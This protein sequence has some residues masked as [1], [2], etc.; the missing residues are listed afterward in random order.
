MAYDKFPLKNLL[1]GKLLRIAELQDKLA[2]ELASKFE[3]VL[4]GGTALWRVYG[5]RRVSLDIDIYHEKPEEVM[6]HF[7][8][9]GAFEMLRGKM[10]GSDV[11]Y[12]KFRGEGDTIVE[13]HVSPPFG[14]VE[15]ADGEFRLVDGSSII[16]KT[17]TPEWLLKEKISAFRNRKK[18]RDLYDIFY[19]LDIADASRFRGEIRSLLP[20][21]KPQDFSGLRELILL[22]K[23]PEFETIE[24]KLRA[25]GSK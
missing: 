10:T 11:L 2:I 24:R 6:E 5:G 18:A 7:S 25:Y 16:L 23:A 19:L 12:M 20:L 9:S 13:L 8:K 17:L 15:A 4:H 21:Q 22:G 1:K 3:F 14:R